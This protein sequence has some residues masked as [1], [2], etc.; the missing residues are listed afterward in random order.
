MRLLISLLAGLLLCLSTAVH[1]VDL[2]PDDVVAPPHNVRSI[3]LAVRHSHA[4]RLYIDGQA[5]PAPVAYT[6]DQAILRLGTGFQLAGMTGYAYAELPYRRP[7]LGGQL[8]ALDAA[9]GPGDLS[10]AAALWPLADRARGRYLGVAGYLTLPSGRYQREHTRGF[11]LNPGGNR[12]AG[13]LQVGFSQRLTPQLNAMVAADVALFG[14]ND[15]YLGPANHPG[16]LQQ[17]PLLSL[18]GGLSYGLHS[19]WRLGLSYYLSRNGETRSHDGDWDNPLDR[20]RVAL[21]MR[22]QPAP[23]TFLILRMGDTVA[24]DNGLRESRLIQLRLRQ[25]F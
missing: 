5:Q 23:R 17:R 15:D 9:S 2:N 6:L 24:I 12:L 14:D 22:Y 8:A 16:V 19:Q 25:F 1:A 10:L 11:N 18:Q 7:E 4:D 21:W 20:H 3:S 13:A